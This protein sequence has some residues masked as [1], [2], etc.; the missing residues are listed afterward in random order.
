MLYE[1][2]TRI[3]GGRDAIFAHEVFG[4][5]LAAFDRRGCLARTKTADSRQIE[6]EYGISSLF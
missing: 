6:K 4:E 3:I 2:I 5:A 1:V